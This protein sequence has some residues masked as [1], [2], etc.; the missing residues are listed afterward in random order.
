MSTHL[1]LNP[2]N[3]LVWNHPT[4]LTFILNKFHLECLIFFSPPFTAKSTTITPNCSPI[5]ISQ[6]KEINPTSST[7]TA[8]SSQNGVS[9]CLLHNPLLPV[10]VVL[11]LSPD[12]VVLKCKSQFKTYGT[13]SFFFFFGWGGGEGSCKKIWYAYRLLHTLAKELSLEAPARVLVPHQISIERIKPQTWQ[14]RVPSTYN[15]AKCFDGILHSYQLWCTTPRTLLKLPLLL[16]FM[17]HLALQFI[18]KSMQLHAFSIY[19][20]FTGNFVKFGWVFR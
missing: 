6:F 3:N 13:I 2:S 9:L 8:F 4:L 15:W 12:C 5:F 10:V 20:L 17:F 19:G 18:Q 1:F 7:M 14:A 16:P 11:D